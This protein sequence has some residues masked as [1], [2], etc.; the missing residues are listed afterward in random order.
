MRLSVLFGVVLCVI[1]AVA[2]ADGGTMRLSER[3][4]G[5]Q[6][7][8]FTSPTPV[9]AGPVDISVLV[10]DAGSFETVDN[11]QVVIHVESVDK[12]EE[13]L[14]QTATTSAATNKLFRAAIFELP[15]AG[16]WRITADIAGHPSAAEV[17]FDL[18]ALDRLPSWLTFWP[19]L[20]WPFAV[21]GLF[22]IHQFLVS[23]RRDKPPRS[24]PTRIR[25]PR[26]QP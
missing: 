13:I 26:F 12:P 21:V 10:Q 19:W 1:P 25:T 20:L 16:R 23:R 22:G 15:A 9:R 24:R 6:I 7:T 18:E 14:T 2:F 5:E 17:H 11:T 3:H 4:G 8:V